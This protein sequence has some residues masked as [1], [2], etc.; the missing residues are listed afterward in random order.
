[1][2]QRAPWLRG[3]KGLFEVQSWPLVDSLLAQ[4]YL[5]YLDYQLTRRLLKIQIQATEKTA[6][7]SAISF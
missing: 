7:L 2:L 1:M 6:Y 3:K 5:S 4:G